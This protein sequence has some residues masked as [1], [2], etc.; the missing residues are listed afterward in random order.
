MELK[1]IRSAGSLEPA[2]IQ[3]VNTINSDV[4]IYW[5]DFN[6]QDIFYSLLQPKLSCKVNTYKNH[7]WLFRDS[8]TGEKMHVAHQ[9][10][11]WPVPFFMKSS[12]NFDE[13]IPCRKIVFIHLPLRTL[14]DCCMWHILRRPF[15]SK[16]VIDDYQIP[17][18]LKKELNNVLDCSFLNRL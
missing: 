14:R 9:E 12:T 7:P 4:M 5:I 16:N 2:Y 1:S 6:G 18:Q 11:F 13:K 15:I 8:L 3:F 10:I 17:L